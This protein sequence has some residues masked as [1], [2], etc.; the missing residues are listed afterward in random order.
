MK[1]AID[2]TGKETKTTTETAGI[3]L[4]IDAPTAGDVTSDAKL[5]VSGSTGKDTTVIITGGKDDVA[6]QTKSGKFSADVALVEGEN[7]LAVYAFD[8]NTGEAAQATVNIL[9]LNE[10]LA[11]RNVLVAASNTDVIETTKERIEDLREQLSTKSADLEESTAIY[12]RAHVFGTI[13]SINKSDLTIETNNGSIKTV[14]TDEFTKFF[15]IGTKGKSTVKLEDLKVG[16]SVSAVGIGKDDPGGK[17]KFVV[18]QKRPMTKRHAASG[19]VKKVSG[20]TFTLT[21]LSQT[22]YTFTVSVG[23]GTVVKIKDQKDAASATDIK[24]GDVVVAAGAVG[25]YGTISATI[26][27]IIPAKI[28]TGQPKEST[29]SATPSSTQ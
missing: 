17:A 12:K 5:A 4:S 22:D 6:T 25:K 18:E 21:Y 24:V 19:K 9:Y 26:V 14:F 13:I 11:R 7:Q 8:T 29:K 23:K 15:S 28:E 20:T 10:E 16:T 1:F 2:N 3:L 27:F